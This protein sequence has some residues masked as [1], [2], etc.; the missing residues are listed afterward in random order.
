MDYHYFWNTPRSFSVDGED[1]E[2]V[3]NFILLGSIIDNNGQCE[4]E[5]RRRI[6]MGRKSFIKLEKIMKDRDVSLRTKIR[7]VYAM[8]FPVF[9]YGCESWTLKKTERKKIDAFEMWT[10]RRLL[11]VPSTAR[12]T[13]KSVLE[14]VKPEH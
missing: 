9:L 14:E 4:Q 3:E 12:R 7:I 11:K 13:N 6:A 2:V 1:I 8:V 10:W 5:V